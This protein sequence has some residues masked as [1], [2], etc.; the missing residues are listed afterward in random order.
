MW[1]AKA[2]MW[3]TPCSSFHYVQIFLA[4]ILEYFGHVD[5]CSDFGICW[6]SSL[7]WLQF[8][9]ILAIFIDFNQWVG[10]N[11]TPGNQ[12]TGENLAVVHFRI[13]FL[14]TFPRTDVQH[15]IIYKRSSFKKKGKFLLKFVEIVEIQTL[16][17]WKFIYYCPN[18]WV[19]IITN[20]HQKLYY[21]ALFVPHML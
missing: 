18:H 1:M 16:N 12:F 7:L 2:T 3:H 10:D 15:K 20:A 5:F 21:F 14:N 6:L 13:L 4:L 8:W 17:L 19:I 11:W 9:N